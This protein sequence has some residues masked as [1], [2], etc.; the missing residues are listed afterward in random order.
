M[1]TIIEDI[2]IGAKY[3]A[4]GILQETTAVICRKEAVLKYGLYLL[5]E[6]I[7]DYKDNYTEFRMIKNVKY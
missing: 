5:V 3:L 1:T 4:E 7:E 6:G 2:A